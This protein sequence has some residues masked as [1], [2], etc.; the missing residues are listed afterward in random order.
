[1]KNNSISFG[2]K[3]INCY[4]ILQKRAKQAILNTKE[5]IAKN[6]LKPLNKKK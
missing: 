5:N 4:N 1:M 3:N 6:L 2:S